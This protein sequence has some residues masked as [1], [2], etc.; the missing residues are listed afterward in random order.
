MTRAKSEMDLLKTRLKW[1]ALGNLFVAL[2]LLSVAGPL[3]AMTL[4]GRSGIAW[5]W[6]DSLWVL[7]LL[8]AVG[9]GLRKIRSF[10]RLWPVE[11]SKLYQAVS[12]R[13]GIAA[14]MVIPRARFMG[15]VEIHFHDGERLSLRLLLGHCYEVLGVIARRCRGA[16]TG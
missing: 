14:A 2:W 4:L 6:D 16:R 1:G 15:D 8:T 3:L 11:R 13:D 5:Q 7:M 12:R 10:K 9:L